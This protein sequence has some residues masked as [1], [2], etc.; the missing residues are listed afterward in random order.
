[1]AHVTHLRGLDRC[2]DA[3]IGSAWIQTVIFIFLAPVIGMALAYGMMIAVYWLFRNASPAKMD[4]YFR[5][6]QLASSALLSFSH[7]GNDAQKTAGIITGVLVASG[8]LKKKLDH[9]EVL[10]VGEKVKAGLLDALNRII[11]EAAKQL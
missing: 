5:R 1:M 2:F 8:V 4:K 11:L 9:R 6:L 3:L 7:G 10:A